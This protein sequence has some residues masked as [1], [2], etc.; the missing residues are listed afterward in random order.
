MDCMVFHGDFHTIVDYIGVRGILWQ[1]AL[2]DHGSRV[3]VH[4]RLADSDDVFGELQ[5]TS[6]HDNREADKDQK[7]A[8]R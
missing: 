6:I 5:K 2:S 8:M 3:R 7:T 4:F 1:Q